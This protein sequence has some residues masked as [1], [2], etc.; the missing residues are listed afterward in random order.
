[1][2]RHFISLNNDI[3]S[4]FVQSDYPHNEYLYE[5]RLHI[6]KNKCMRLMYDIQIDRLYTIMLDYA[7]LRQRVN[8]HTIF[9]VCRMELLALQ[10]A[11]NQ[12]LFEKIVAFSNKKIESSIEILLEKIDRFE[13]IYQNVLRVTAPDPMAFLLFIDSLRMFA[14]NI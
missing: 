3:F 11:I 4:C 1:M 5:R 13:N 14:K 9:A 12:I 7:L 2:L 10:Q 8:D 6:Q